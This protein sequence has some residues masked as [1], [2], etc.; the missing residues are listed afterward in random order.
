[1]HPRLVLLVLLAALAPSCKTVDCG[2]GTTERN[3]SCVP[4]SETVGTAQCGP[5]TELHGDRCEPMLPPTICDPATT[6]PDIDAMGVTTCIGTG[7]G[8]C[9]ARLAC[10]APTDGKH[11]ICG[12][13]YDFENNQPFAQA[14]AM[15][16]QCAAGAT[17]GP[18]ALGIRTYDAV[19]F[20]ANPAVALPL[21]NGGVYVDD[22]GRYK[23]SEI[24]LPGSTFIALAID[25]ATMPGPP[26]VTNAVGVATGAAANTATKD[27]EAFIVRAATYAGWM[28]S[29]GPSLAAGIYAPVYRGHRTGTDLASGVTFSFAPMSTPANLM[30][31]PSRD[32]Y[33]TP[34][35]TNRATVD[36]AANATT[37]NG[38]A[39]VSGANLL[40]VYAGLGGLPSQCLWEYHAGAAIPGAIFIQIFRPMNA[41]GMTCPL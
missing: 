11:T 13:L 36:A 35:S 30:T 39:L 10:P 9:A 29:G 38:T 1:M 12:Q 15:G 34:G 23:I 37:T 26:G 3:G 20:A 7:G 21:A 31:D 27:L 8:G 5:F 40:E 17:T 28:G 14:G 18:C 25:D 6:T 2:D 33:F 22:C 24:T 19:A 32:F 41:P 16:T 4:A